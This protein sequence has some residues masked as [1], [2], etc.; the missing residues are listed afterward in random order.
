MRKMIED[1]DYSKDHALFVI[2]NLDK[3]II[4][5]GKFTCSIDTAIFVVAGYDTQ[6]KIDN[7]MITILEKLS[8]KVMDVIES[9]GPYTK[10]NGEETPQSRTRKIK[11]SKM[12]MAY[13]NRNID[14]SIIVKPH[15][16]FL[17]PKN[18]R[19]G[20]GYT[21]LRRALSELA[22]SFNVQFHFSA[23]K[24]KT[25]LSLNVENTQKIDIRDHILRK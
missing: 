7:V 20:P 4:N 2:D 13:H 23:V 17:F 1:I 18:Y 12:L 22:S 3:N 9:K 21:Y 19:L 6:K 25:G 11:F 16:H 14:G 10:K 24:R 15:F 5:Y 8:E